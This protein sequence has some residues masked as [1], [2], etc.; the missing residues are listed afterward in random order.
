MISV[1]ERQR[2]HRA[3]PADRRQKRVL[4]PQLHTMSPTLQPDRFRRLRGDFETRRPRRRRI[5]IA[6][7]HHTG[8]SRHR[9]AGTAPT[10]THSS[11]ANT[12]DMLASA[13]VNTTTRP[14]NPKDPSTPTPRTDTG[15]PTNTNP[16]RPLSPHTM[17]MGQM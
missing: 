6:H 17:S 14:A 15:L 3:H 2:A 9:R 16:D 5:H 13:L 11:H 12:R 1:S 8:G 10:R 4:G 7:H